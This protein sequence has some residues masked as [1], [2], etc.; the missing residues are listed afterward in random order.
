MDIDNII[1]EAKANGVTDELLIMMKKIR[2]HYKDVVKDPL[3]TKL[4][5]LTYTHIEKNDGKYGIEFLEER[6]STME[7]LIYMFELMKRPNH[8]LNREELTEYKLL[9]RATGIK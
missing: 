3:I 1:D 6:E 9:L 7:D 5:R 2:P 8:P 4:L